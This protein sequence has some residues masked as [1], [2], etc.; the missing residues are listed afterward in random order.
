[1]SGDF[2]FSDIL[3]L[4]F[5]DAVRFRSPNFPSFRQLYTLSIAGSFFA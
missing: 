5:T 3:G 1:M 2:F 4:R